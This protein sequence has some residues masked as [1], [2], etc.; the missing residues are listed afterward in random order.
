MMRP[1]G[2]AF[3]GIAYLVRTQRNFRLHLLAA[4]AVIAVGAALG[5]GPTEWAILAATIGLVIV[6]EALN[7]GIEL[8]VTLAS[9]ERRPEAKAAKDIAA[10]AVLISAITAL[11]VGVAVFGP[12]LLVII[13]P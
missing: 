4:A 3:A 6:A 12:R 5:V 1:F 8:A 13:R 11:A 9:P 2:Y 7:T 10:G